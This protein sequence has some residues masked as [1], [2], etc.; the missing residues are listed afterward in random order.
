M[1]YLPLLGLT[2]AIIW[3]ADRS[4]ANTPAAI[5][6]NP[7]VINVRA[8]DNSTVPP[9][10]MYA[11]NLSNDPQ[12][13]LAKLDR[14]V[15]QNP[16][17]AAAYYNRGVLKHEQLNDPKGAV[18]DYDRAIALNPKAA[19][20]YYSRGL[21]KS[22]GLNDP[23]GAVADFDR[24]ISLNPQF[25][26]AY[27]ARGTLKAGKLNDPNGAVA[28]LNRAIALNPK[29]AQAY[30][31]RGGLKYASGDRAG[32]I[33]DLRQAAKLARAQGNERYLQRVLQGLQSLGVRE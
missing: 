7:S 21:L 1:K 19:D 27:T 5:A 15:L 13:D 26:L 25:A 32:G 8:I 14:A 4:V 20:T 24:A 23:N 9:G 11:L 30:G 31:A 12:A 18:A 28:D 3:S 10:K 6:A 22:G 2:I 16:N 29:L 33:A 17:D